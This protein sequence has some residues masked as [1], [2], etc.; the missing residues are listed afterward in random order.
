MIEI[1][2][3]PYDDE[4][5]DVIPQ[6]LFDLIEEYFSRDRDSFNLLKLGQRKFKIRRVE[7]PFILA[8]NMFDLREANNDLY[9]IGVKRTKVISFT[10]GSMYIEFVKDGDGIIIHGN[11]EEG[12][13]IFLL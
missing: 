4:V 9:E 10:G 7:S 12:Y 2:Y 6:K 8:D 13:N 5:G 1:D 3:S 11:R